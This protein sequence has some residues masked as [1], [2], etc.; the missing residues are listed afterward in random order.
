MGHRITWERMGAKAAQD[1]LTE[2]DCPYRRPS[3]ARTCWLRGILMHLVS[4]GDLN[5]LAQSR[6]GWLENLLWAMVGASLGAFIPAMEAL[7]ATFFAE[8]VQVFGVLALLKII[9]FFVTAALAAM[10]AFVVY[11]KGKTG[12]ELLRE[13][14]A[15][16][17]Y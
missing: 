6:T 11:R 5:D 10:A 13:I 4:D 3:T 2:S 17:K 8:P 9:A 7:Y 1:G 12:Q 14:R 15:R 16:P